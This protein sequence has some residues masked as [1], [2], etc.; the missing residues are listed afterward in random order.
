MRNA[1][2]ETRDS[3]DGKTEI[4]SGFTG[5][6]VHTSLVQPDAASLAP[7]RALLHICR[8]AS[9]LRAPSWAYALG[10]RAIPNVSL[11]GTTSTTAK[12]CQ[13]G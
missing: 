8:R 9:R 5:I 13:A 1:K 3:D 6:H 10:T 12:T 7:P 4:P 2:R 11:I